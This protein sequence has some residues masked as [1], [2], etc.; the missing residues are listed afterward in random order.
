[1]IST[2]DSWGYHHSEVTLSGMGENAISMAL[3]AEGAEDSRGGIHSHCG[4]Y[5]N[6]EES[7]V[8]VI[9]IHVF[10]PDR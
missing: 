10:H 3:K 9:I 1:M 6:L 8:G 4:W 7:M 5:V 2:G